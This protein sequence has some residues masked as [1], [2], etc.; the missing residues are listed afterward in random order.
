[1]GEADD[2]AARGL[3]GAPGLPEGWRWARLGD[4]CDLV[5]EPVNPARFGDEEVAHYSVPS[6]DSGNGPTIEP[7]IA[8]QSGKVLFPSGTVLFCKLNPRINRVWYVADTLTQKRICS[9]E[10]MP[11]LPRPGALD[12]SFL[13]WALRDPGFGDQVRAH[14]RA[15]TKSRERLRPQV[16]TR[17]LIPLP[18]LPEQKRIVAILNEQMEAV[19][20]ARAAAGEQLEAA[21][22]LP[23]AYLREVFESAKAKAWPT[24]R[25]GDYCRLLPART[26]S[27]DGDAEVTAVTTACLSELG[28]QASGLKRARMRSDAAQEAKLSVGEVLV[29]RSNTPDLVGRVAMYVGEPPSIVASDLTIRL[30]PTDGVTS[31][32]LSCYLSYLY[33]TGYWRQ[34]AGG[35]SG[36]MKKI[37]RRQIQALSVPLPGRPVQDRVGSYI[38]GR[39][40]GTARLVTALEAGL[41]DIERLAPRLLRQAFRG[42][43]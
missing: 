39:M 35:A 32:F 17:A 12:A 36:S 7:G 9:T 43:L 10:F 2:A 41:V 29:A 37:T 6:Y 31:R 16:V 4:V 42:E 8:V 28:F 26:I 23:A 22:A 5:G 14:A 33:V 11:L 27:T 18:P 1:M 13:A 38:E 20:R 30:M 19:E 21:K 3:G 34:R 24:V 25:L 40:T 15:A